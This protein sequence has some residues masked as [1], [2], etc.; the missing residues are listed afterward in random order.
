MEQTS[1]RVDKWLWAIRAFKSRNIATEA[2][3]GGKVAINGINAKPSKEVKV[4]DIVSVKKMPVVYSFKVLEI[5]SKRQ[6]AK[7]VSQYAEN[8]TPQ[9][10]LDKLE[11]Q[12]GVIFMQRDRGAGRPTKRERRDI[13][14]L[15][16]EFFYEDDME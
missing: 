11:M 10:E 15:M 3:K 6:G 12:K 14:E 5:I 16:D 13:D 8:V 1:E 7:L 2:C 9:S 4:G